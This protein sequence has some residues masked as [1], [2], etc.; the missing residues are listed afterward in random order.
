MHDRFTTHMEA[1]LT[2][3]SS[4]CAVVCSSADRSEIQWFLTFAKHPC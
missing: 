3:R 1:G 4:T 2:A